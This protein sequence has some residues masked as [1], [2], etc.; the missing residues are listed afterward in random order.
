MLGYPTIVYP[1]IFTILHSSLQLFC[2]IQVLI[3]SKQIITLFGGNVHM[4]Q[5]LKILDFS[6]LLPGPFATLMLVDLGAEVL[7]VTKEGESSP[8]VNEDYLQRSK[9]SIA[10]NL[11]DEAIKEKI[12]EL[13]KE[14]DIVVEQFR[15]GVMERLGLGYEALKN[16]NPKVIYCSITG[17]GQT[18]H[19]KHR[20]GHDI[21]YVSMAGIQGY[22]GSQT[23][24]PANL[25]VQI[26]DIAGGSLHAVIGILAA[27][28][29][30]EKTGEGQ[31]LDI[32]MTDCVLTMNALSAPNYLVHGK[33]LEREK[34]MLNGGTFYGFY[35]TRDGRHFSVGSLEPKF[36]KALCEAIG[37]P[38]LLNI[39]MQ[40]KP[41][42]DLQLKEELKVI[43]KERT[44]EEWKKIF[45]KAD[46][47]VEPVLTFEEAASHPLFQERKM[48]VEVD[49]LTGEKQMQIACPIKSNIF[50]PT[51]QHVG[52]KNNA[53]NELFLKK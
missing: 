1:I 19:Y 10:V 40:M 47:C 34:M 18:G 31:H 9:K 43:F 17:Y 44:F 32:S 12:K 52:V 13:V 22:S 45:E 5:G 42:T 23:E 48:F 53:Y 20:G 14:Y 51:Y 21:N 15:P 38:D 4:L 24:G 6:T 3:V 16:I 37:R 30:R 35:E 50:T 28:Y 29:L 7:H 41:E 33:A 25:G 39:A 2:H 46:A 8:L 27:V 26:A 11:K 49:S 36:R